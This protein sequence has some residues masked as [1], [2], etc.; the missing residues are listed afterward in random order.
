M[1]LVA[2]REPLRTE[3]SACCC[4]LLSQEIAQVAALAATR[5]HHLA[6]VCVA[7]KRRSIWHP[8]PEL[9]TKAT[10]LT[11]LVCM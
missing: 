2:K 10:L 3:L 6:P 5:C 7:T 4:L 1:L 9:Q 11:H 8:L